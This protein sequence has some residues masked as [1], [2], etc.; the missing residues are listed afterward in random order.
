MTHLIV[1]DQPKKT[2]VRVARAENA[3]ALELGVAM[4]SS[5]ALA[6]DDRSIQQ[7]KVSLETIA[8]LIYLSRH[9]ETHCAQQHDYLDRAAK[10]LAEIAHHPICLLES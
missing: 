8:S 5:E 1:L 10:V 7:L 4:S 6:C 2:T 9:T 3:P